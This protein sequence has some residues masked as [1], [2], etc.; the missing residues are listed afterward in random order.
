M[1]AGDAQR[2]W[3][4]ENGRNASDMPAVKSTRRGHAK[5]SSRPLVLVFRKGNEEGACD[6]F[7]VLYFRLWIA[8]GPPFS[9]CTPC[10]WNSPV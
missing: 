10:G 4:A 6:N 1:P 9:G 2:T 3:F 7:Y 5:K 8:I